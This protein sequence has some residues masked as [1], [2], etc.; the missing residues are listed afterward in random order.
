[1]A[2]RG[3]SEKNDEESSYRSSE[4]D[5][6]ISPLPTVAD[7]CPELGIQVSEPGTENLNTTLT[8]PRKRSR[9]VAF[10]ESLVGQEEDLP[11]RFPCDP[12]RRSRRKAFYFNPHNNMDNDPE[13]N[14]F[15]HLI[16]AE[17]PASVQP[18]AGEVDVPIGDL[19]TLRINKLLSDNIFWIS[20]T[21]EI[22]NSVAK[23]FVVKQFARGDTIL[24]KGKTTT[25]FYVIESGTLTM[26]EKVLKEGDT[27]GEMTLVRGNFEATED[28]VAENNLKLWVI[29]GA[30]YRYIQNKIY[31]EKVEEAG[32]CSDSEEVTSPT[33]V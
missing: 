4:R 33:T 12:S 8:S 30:M 28:F 5:S 29:P 17:Q 25:N 21:E 16:L 24:A 6:S 3:K 13:N 31:K 19:K 1:M 26:G 9:L 15:R 27:I 18:G 2:A 22:K 23:E 7:K 11:V 20:L 10:G 32:G 14:L